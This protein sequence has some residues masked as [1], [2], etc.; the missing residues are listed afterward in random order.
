[1]QLPDT[2]AVESLR[3]LLRVPLRGHFNGSRRSLLDHTSSRHFIVDRSDSVEV[4]ALTSFIT[5]QISQY[6]IEIA[7]NKL[8]SDILDKYTETVDIVAEGG[9]S[10]LEILEDISF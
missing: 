2:E 10:S 7:D 5:K 6:M 1:M 9:L 8:M 3:L 4:P